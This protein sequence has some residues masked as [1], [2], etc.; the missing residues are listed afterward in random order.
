MKP[1]NVVMSAFGPYA[2]KVEL[3]FHQLGNNGLF[4]ITGD[5]GA[6]KTT[7]F[8]AIAF[9]LFDGASGSVRTVDTL[10]SDFSSHDTQ[11]YVKLEFSHKG[12][13]Y[14]LTRNPKYERPKKNGTGFTNQNADATLIL[15]SG[16]IVTGNTKVTDKIVEL[17][18][19]DFKQFKQIAMIA[20]GEF[21]KLLLAES[22]ERAGIF[23][24]VFNTNIYMSLQEVLKRRERDLK[25][26]CEESIRSILQYTDGIQCDKAH[27]NYLQ[28]SEL[29]S[30]R[31][32]H[33]TE[34]MIM[35]MKTLIAEDELMNVSSKTQ[36]EELAKLS[37]AKTSELKEA[38]YVNRSFAGLETARKLLRGLLQRAD[39]IE[40]NEAT[41]LAAE[42]ALHGVRPL[43]DVY[44]REKRRH[45]EL[46][47][48]MKKLRDTIAVQT[49]QVKELHT[50]L[51]TEQQREPVREKFASD[52][53]KLTDALPQYNKVEKLKQDKDKQE[54]IVQTLENSLV[55]LK[56]QKVKLVER[57]D[58]LSK[59]RDGLSDVETRLLECK[60]TII[61][62]VAH[63]TNIN[64]IADGIISVHKMRSEYGRLQGSYLTAEKLYIVTNDEYIHKESAFFC[65]QAGILATGLEEGLP[66]PVCG[67]TEHP[68]KAK[69]TADAPSEADIQR[70]KT[71]RD[72]KQQIMQQASQNAN[73][74]KTQIETSEAHL[75]QTARNVI[76]HDLSDS[77]SEL[78]LHV[79]S[80]LEKATVTNQ[81][82]T[83]ARHVLEA[84]VT[85]KTEC[86]EQ[87]G[88]NE[89]IFQKTEVAYTEQS[90]QKAD[91]VVRLSAMNSEI[92]TLQTVLEHLSIEKAQQTIVETTGKLEASKSVLKKAENAYLV[93]NR[94]L[95]SNN[96]LIQDQIIRLEA[97]TATLNE[98]LADYTSKYTEYGFKDENSYHAA[99]LAEHSLA[100]LKK[101]IADYRDTCKS[102]NTDIVRLSAETDH[103]QLKDTVKI[104]EQQN[105][106]QREKDILDTKIQSIVAR[107]QCNKTI[108]KEVAKAETERNELEKAYLVVTTLSKTANGELA[109]KQKLAFE[110]FVQASY[111]NQIIAEANKRLSGLSNG[112]YDLLRK[113]NATDLRSQS[114]LELDVL[115]NYT[116]KIRTVKSLSGGESF[117][118]SLSLALG[119]SDVIQS[120]AGG[121]EI[122]TMFIDEGFGALDAESLEQA[123]ITLNSLTSG[124]RLVGIISHVS[125]L[126]DRID[127]KIVIKKGIGG[128]TLELVR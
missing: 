43:E 76:E 52:I 128:S 56:L 120:Y 121:V 48:S 118:A 103:K 74:K 104:L 64:S 96:T 37:M 117:K 24:K 13:D 81:E 98:A 115:D 88:L 11:T 19:L 89:N 127:K 72:E 93:N 122:D 65:E 91:L 63:K 16:E 113:E 40:R 55:A 42:K 45:V 90:E 67:A 126:K 69:S 119:L 110:Q 51:L 92:H 70:L 9:A 53:T 35:L 15:P 32:I 44:L 27:G 116:G 34:Q 25:A 17:L 71:Q 99:L 114:G 28:L 80:E 109:G 78:Q 18:G 60:N 68:Q 101:N 107:L 123:I 62:L 85:R 6:G 87:L 21:L 50:A 79:Q 41:A 31:S 22:N 4:L 14:T 47:T 10:R 38:E 54:K 111:F 105:A 86:M 12:Q 58:K 84:Q 108:S 5:T 49:P 73:V 97:V 125:E 61:N 20:Q 106:L 33:G 46:T 102:T 57:K 7:I 26:R 2:G 112:R 36:S 83:A 124:N 82:Q 8:D 77:L 66:C 94:T 75:F 100:D 39:D 1:L 30:Q 59:E 3:P 29:L 95:D 23:R